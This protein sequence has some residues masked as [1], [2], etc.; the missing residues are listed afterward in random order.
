MTRREQIE[1][2]KRTRALLLMFKEENKK[3]IKEKNKENVYVKTLG[4][5]PLEK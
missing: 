5:H 1:R 3:A 2:L 4:K